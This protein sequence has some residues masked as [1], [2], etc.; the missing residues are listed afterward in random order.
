[1]KLLA[2]ILIVVAILQVPLALASAFGTPALPYFEGK[3][4]IQPNERVDIPINL[5]LQ[6]SKSTLLFRFTFNA[7][8]PQM[9]A[10]AAQYDN[11]QIV[12]SSSRD[13]GSGT[14]E[15][16]IYGI[17][18][19]QATCSQD[20]PCL[21]TPMSGSA[22]IFK[23]PVVGP[24][25]SANTLYTFTMTSF[26]AYGQSSPA[27]NVASF[28]RAEIL[29]LKIIA[30]RDNDWVDDALDN[31]PNH[32]NP[33]QKNT[34]GIIVNAD[35]E[36][37][38]AGNC[39]FGWVCNDNAMLASAS[40]G[41]GCTK[42]RGIRGSQYAKAGCDNSIGSLKS[43]P[44]IIPST[45]KGLRFLRA[46]GAEGSTGSGLFVIDSN[47]P[48]RMLCAA[49]S[50]ESSENTDTFF[51]D[52]CDL[53]GAA[54]KNV[55]IQISDNARSSWGKVYIDN[56]KLLDAQSREI[57]D[58]AGDA[59]DATPFGPNSLKTGQGVNQCKRGYRQES[60]SELCV[61]R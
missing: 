60:S 18:A 5:E 55:M 24:S 58:D 42:A 21:A 56:L 28:S 4:I 52:N 38:S 22:E 33:D 14:T 51:Q 23:I 12:S 54:G 9:G 37:G 29:Q 48:D 46:G 2:L 25:A 17:I 20:Q 11:V 26:K 59:C 31:C 6:P 35:F 8:I 1:M 30:D 10:L 16:T 13:V 40:N 61:P 53:T 7:N 43:P 15:Y 36:R 32:I 50:K 19:P 34:D 3:Y 49:W 41:Q 27:I 39:P 45:V 57:N 47:N 44:F